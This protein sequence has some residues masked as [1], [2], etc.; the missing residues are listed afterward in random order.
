MSRFYA[1]FA[2]DGAPVQVRFGAGARHD[3]SPELEL[4]G[5]ARALVLTTPH[6][7]EQG[8]DI[9]R[10]LGD[11]AVGL[12]SGA[13]MHT[14]VET[15]ETAMDRAKDCGADGVVAI[16]G[17]S[18]IGLAK[19]V[20]WRSDLPQIVLPTTYAGSEA[21]PVLG[22]TENGVKSTFASQRVQP[23]AI[24]YD[25]ELVATLPAGL[26][27]T[28][29]LNAMAHAV[30]GLYSRDANRLSSAL[31]MEGIRAFVRGLPNVVETPGDLAAREDTLFGAWLCGTVLGQVGMA[32]HH[33]LCHTLGGTLGLPHSET[34]AIV[35]PHAVA[36]NEGAARDALKPV[37]DLLGADTAA[38]GLYILA[39]RL[40]AP[41]ALRDLGVSQDALETVADLAT[42]NPYWNPR[43]V[44]RAALRALL[45]DAYLGDPP[46][47]GERQ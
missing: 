12:F 26:T 36:Y 47:S 11:R 9:V 10:S 30:E 23:E 35:L 14:P 38:G 1:G 27:V 34:H 40:G 25:P 16:G 15:T 5:I 33:K 22:Q 19:A 42:Q 4:L 41:L 32:L 37:A 17:G 13:A 7:A 46:N 31:A 21:T 44:E 29:A 20:A 39:K 18:T 3:L 45:Q 6:Q 2:A 28:S 24:V 8:E 43:P